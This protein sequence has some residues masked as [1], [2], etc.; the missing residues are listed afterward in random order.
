MNPLEK[1]RIRGNIIKEYKVTDVIPIGITNNP[2]SEYDSYFPSTIVNNKTD[3]KSELQS[4]FGYVI[5]NTEDPI[6]L[7]ENDFPLEINPGI[8]G[9]LSYQDSTTASPA[10]L[11]IKRY[12]E[13]DE[14]NTVYLCNSNANSAD[15][16]SAGTKNT[17]FKTLRYALSHIGAK[18]KLCILDDAAYNAEAKILFSELPQNIHIFSNYYPQMPEIEILYSASDSLF[19]HYFSGL[20]WN[21][22]NV[23]AGTISRNSG[24][25]LQFENCY[26]LSCTVDLQH[27][28]Y[29]SSDPTITSDARINVFHSIFKN[30]TVKMGRA[31]TPAG[32]NGEGEIY[33]YN[34][35][36]ILGNYHFA[37]ALR[38]ITTKKTFLAFCSFAISSTEIYSIILES[39]V[40][41]Y[42]S[43]FYVNTGY[44]GF[45]RNYY[46][47]VPSIPHSPPVVDYCVFNKTWMIDGMEGTSITNSNWKDNGRNQLKT[48]ENAAL[49]TSLSVV[50]TTGSETDYIG[51]DNAGYQDDF[52]YNGIQWKSYLF[53]SSVGLML[54][55]I[56][57]DASHQIDGLFHSGD[58]AGASIRQCIVRNF[59]ARVSRSP[60]SNSLLLYNGIGMEIS[61]YQEMERNVFAFNDISIAVNQTPCIINHNTFFSNL[62]G[63]YNMSGV[64]DVRNCILFGNLAYA[65]K[66]NIPISIESGQINVID[67]LPE[68]LDISSGTNISF[69]PFFKS[70]NAGFLDLHLRT[71]EEGYDF[72]S[73]AKECSSDNPAQDLGAYHVNRELTGFYYGIDFT[74]DR[75]HPKRCKLSE[76]NA[77]VNMSRNGKIFSNPDPVITEETVLYWE[78]LEEND[79]QNLIKLWKST[80]NVIEI[81]EFSE[82]GPDDYTVYHVDKRQPLNFERTDN[83][84]SGENIY[85]QVELKLLRK[86]EIVL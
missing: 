73:V 77:F 72:D 83:F 43:S 49:S 78:T 86:P 18:T 82:T 71:K 79:I 19:S 69:N 33:F 57:I 39:A 59:T 55:N 4:G 27:T 63:I 2:S 58:G 84:H 17:P 61:D 68:N 76:I 41:V 36:C 45:C 28:H 62:C 51:I 85:I 60:M 10:L 1:Y 70:E 81:F 74:I 8:S 21:L 25:V 65:I 38:G 13:D 22:R 67:M 20:K 24:S 52:Y 6:V 50:T 54:Y 42:R 16:I 11:K 30:C 48:Y 7:N 44:T 75:P 80:D 9:V 64:P 14:A 37:G 40:H 15:I 31:L 34:N 3:L 35:R 53:T 12:N 47:G 56:D 23:T 26:F 29:S 5:L 66:S 46:T 32:A